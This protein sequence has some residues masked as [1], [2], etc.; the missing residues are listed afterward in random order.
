[1]TLLDSC[2]TFTFLINENYIIFFGGTAARATQCRKVIISFL[3]SING[4]KQTREIIETRTLFIMKQQTM[5]ASVQYVYIST[6]FRHR[7]YTK[8]SASSTNRIVSYTVP[9]ASLNGIKGKDLFILPR[10]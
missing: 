5:N 10:T 1:M 8:F 7:D 9:R 3:Y 4:T 2:K 6:H